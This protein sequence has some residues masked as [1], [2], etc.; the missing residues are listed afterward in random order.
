MRKNGSVDPGWLEVMDIARIET[1]V[2][3]GCDESAAKTLAEKRRLN[4]LAYNQIDKASR[5]QA[6]HWSAV[7]RNSHPY[8][9][10]EGG[11]LWE[12]VAAGS[13]NEP[14]DAP[15][16]A[17]VRRF[18]TE[19][20]AGRAAIQGETV[21]DAGLAGFSEY[22]KMNRVVN[23]P[24]LIWLTPP[25]HLPACLWFWNMRALRS[26]AGG[27]SPMILLPTSYKS[28]VGLRDLIESVL[29]RHYHG[30]V[31]V[32]IEAHGR[33]QSQL[34]ELIERFGLQPYTSNKFN[35]DAGGWSPERRVPP[36]K[37]IEGFDP[38]K[39]LL[40][41][42]RAGYHTTKRV[43]R[44]RAR[45][46]VSLAVPSLKRA[47]PDA[48]GFP[49]Y[50]R[51]SGGF[52]SD[53]PRTDRTAAL[54]QDNARWRDVELELNSIVTPNPEIA[55]SSPD[56]MQILEALLQGLHASTRDSDK[57][58]LAS[59]INDARSG[60]VLLERETLPLIG[61]LRT[62]RSRD[63]M[64]QLEQLASD[65]PA[66]KLEEIASTL[67]GR[68]GRKFASALSLGGTSALAGLEMLVGDGWA[69]RGLALK[70][71]RC[72][73]TS[74]VQLSEVTN[75]AICPGCNSPGKYAAAKGLEVMYRLDTLVDRAS[76]QGALPHLAALMALRQRSHET[77]LSMG[78]QIEWPDGSSQEA[79]LFGFMGSHIISGEVKTS[80]S[81]FDASQIER[82]V[83]LSQRLNADIHV[84][85]ATQEIPH[86][87]IRLAAERCTQ[88]ALQLMVLMPSEHAGMA[89]IAI[90][91]N[92]SE[93]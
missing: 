32:V 8:A 18:G 91:A 46:S 83:Q 47:I 15:S 55:I 68:S 6:M 66:S 33:A 39:W 54:I 82:D 87:A 76:D 56:P 41:K 35:Y 77:Y 81:E 23:A 57:G 16:L 2:N 58:R 69:E 60:T 45:T 85:A 70:C 93:G 30:D 28:W 12:M 34:G 9:A 64:K 42:R 29:S 36:F 44:F 50:Y 78:L 88:A 63:V 65:A 10:R 4:H 72:G 92:L 27:S 80:A 31:D 84:M 20:I 3:V 40:F 24:A 61:K 7:A 19:D 48:T 53:M 25:N 89:I 21:L 73:V 1:V 59:A 79:D 49:V 11:P 17:P 38:R 52:L 14:T 51:L 5:P 67:G 71:P 22:V 62:P 43:Q 13:P 37:Y 86:T 26:L 74:F 75:A 90:P